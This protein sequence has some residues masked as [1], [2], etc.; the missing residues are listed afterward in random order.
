MFCF[1][2]PLFVDLSIVVSVVTRILSSNST[3]F[4]NGWPGRCFL[5]STD[6]E[7]SLV[8]PPCQCRLVC[9]SALH[10]AFYGFL[11][12]AAVISKKIA[13]QGLLTN[14]TTACLSPFL[15]PVLLLFWRISGGGGRPVV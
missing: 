4:P 2:H 5:R 8:R 9:F 12:F 6:E 14:Q 15:L 10:F 1:I 13:P 3:L 7:E 11:Y